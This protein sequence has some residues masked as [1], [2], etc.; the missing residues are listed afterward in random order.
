MKTYSSATH[1]ERSLKWAVLHQVGGI[2]IRMSDRCQSFRCFLFAIGF[3]FSP[4]LCSSVDE[5]VDAATKPIV[6]AQSVHAALHEIFADEHCPESALSICRRVQQMTAEEQYDYLFR[7]VFPTTAPE[8]IQIPTVRIVIDFTPTDPAPP[9]ASGKSPSGTRISTGGQLVSPALALIEAAEAAGKLDELLN[10]LRT[11]PANNFLSQKNRAALF[12]M[13]YNRLGEPQKAIEELERFCKLSLQPH[14]DDNIFR[15]SEM[16]VSEACRN[17]PG[18]AELLLSTIE[19]IVTRH[20]QSNSYVP[21]IRQVRS[22]QSLYSAVTVEE[23]SGTMPSDSLWSSAPAVSQF[24]RGTGIPAS[25][26][27]QSSGRATNTVSHGDDYL[28]FAIPMRG[29]FQIECDVSA[30]N[31]SEVRPC[32]AA[33]WVSP[34]YDH[35][36]FESGNLRVTHQWRPIAPPLTRIFDFLHMRSR[37][38]GQKITTSANG[39]VIHQHEL[40]VNHDPWVAM[41]SGAM[42]VGWASNVRITGSPEIPATIEMTATTELESWVPYCDGGVGYHWLPVDGGGMRSRPISEATTSTDAASGDKPSDINPE[43]REEAIFYNRPMLEDG[44]I[45]Y[46]FFYREGQ[47]NTHPAMDRLCLLM[48]PDGIRVHWLT[49]GKYE[50]TE[51]APDNETIEPKNRL[52]PDTLPLMNETWNKVQFSLQGDTIEV[53][54]NS[55]PVYRRQLESTNLRRFG[56]FHFAEQE[57]SLVRNV[58][59]TGSWPKSLPDLTQ[60]S[61]AILETEMLDTNNDH[62]AFSY[63]HDFVENGL[64]E[65]GVTSIQ[66]AIGKNFVVTGQGVVSTISGT[67]GYRNASLAPRISVEGD[68]DIT[69]E[70]KDFAARPSLKGSSSLLLVAFLQSKAS[71]EYYITRR[72]M[73]PSANSLQHI[74]QCV[75]VSNLGEN[76]KREYFATRNVEEQSGR[77]RLSRRGTKMYYLTSEGDSPNFRLIGTH[78]CAKD[79]VQMDGIRLVNQIHEVGE[80][81]VVWKNI[82]VRA[83]RLTGAALGASDVRLVKL[84]EDRD[85]LPINVRYDFQNKP[86]S[87]SALFRWGDKRPWNKDLQGL[88]ILAS[89]TSNW[90][91]SGIKTQQPIVGDFDIR[92]DFHDIQ[93][94]LPQKGQGTGVFLQVDFTD[95]KKTQISAIFNLTDAGIYEF[96]SQIR[97]ND[98]SGKPTYRNTGRRNTSSAS[99]LRIARRGTQIT[100][101]SRAS[102]EADDLIISEFEA[103]DTAVS[104]LKVQ[105]HTGGPVGDSQ[106]TFKTLDI[107]ASFYEPLAA[108]Q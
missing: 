17:L 81:Q 66:G 50:R 97:M 72:H 20:K 32:V 25:H 44:T 42:Q 79:P 54:L 57:D 52:L 74:V 8:A 64:P 102:P 19:N 67:G 108:E 73:I 100:V 56:F 28:Y 89:G 24:T 94:K 11:V 27:V 39:R 34:V 92:V 91:S 13:V 43:Y 98:Q 29:N 60:Q 1:T 101:I 9:V 87:E 41:R 6:A 76:S 107:K 83:E 78:D 95:E 45:E 33:Q 21:W 71:E 62:L 15:A 99:S 103:N 31:W 53:S 38:T 65:A 86:P 70:Y 26:W 96:D 36:N 80:S 68:F 14:P 46:E 4:D 3:L 104:D 40:P 23:T 48:K 5:T 7:L 47:L 69:A 49:D 59:W 106:V 18:T 58:R 2:Q 105:V 55:K 82:S 35:K 77:L 12:V 63:Q 75:V 85:L 93:L 61:L 22:R 30:F 88:P 16:V 51:L 10:H 37:V 84:N 90:T